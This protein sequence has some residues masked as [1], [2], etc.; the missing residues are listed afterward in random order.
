VRNE[1]LAR[2]ATEGWWCYF[3][4]DPGPMPLRIQAT[5]KGYRPVD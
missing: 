3:T 1:L 5:E 2:A 4:H